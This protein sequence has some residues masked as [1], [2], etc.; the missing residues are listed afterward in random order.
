M[1]RAFFLKQFQLVAGGRI[2]LTPG[3][4]SL[5]LDSIGPDTQV[6]LRALPPPPVTTTA[7]ATSSLLVGS[8]INSATSGSNS[9][10]SSTGS[11]S[12]T[13]SSNIIIFRV[14]A[15]STSTTSSSTTTLEALQSGT[16]TNPYGISTSYNS[17]GNGSQTLTAVSGTFTSAGNIIEPLPT[18]QPIQTVPPAPPGVILKVNHIRGDLS[19]PIN[20]Q[21]DAEIFG[22]DHTTQQIV[23]FDLNLNTKTAVVDPKF[24]PI[25]VPGN[26]IAAG[27]DLAW[28]GHMRVLLFS[29]G[30]TVYAYNPLT[31][32]ELGS[33]TD[34]GSFL[35]SLPINAVAGTDTLVVLGS[36][37]TNELYAINLTKSLQTGVAQPAAGSPASFIPQPQFYLLGG[38]TSSPGN[39]L[40]F[41]TIAAHLDTT[42]PDMFQLG[43]QAVGTATVTKV[44]G[45]G[46]VLS[47]NTFTA[48]A[49][50]AVK[51]GTAYINVSNTLP[52]TTLP[53]PALGSIDQSLAGVESSNGTTNT[54]D[55]ETGTYTFDYPDPLMGLSESFRPDLVGSALIDVQGTVQNIRGGTATGMVLNDT[56]NLNLVKFNSISNS[57]I[58]GQPVGHLQ[59][60]HRSHVLVLTPSRDVY[61]RNGVTVNKNLTVIGPL[62]QPN[63]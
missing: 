31:G 25:S 30:T 26:P 7:L 15:T 4:N 48:V 45:M 37:H 13:S 5:I 23:R 56:G 8:N 6:S 55:T 14:F 38:L 52:A 53:G 59:F 41:G 29:S 10:T 9:T 50:V 28:D 42:Q 47:N 20:V 43:V 54:V 12:S 19:A 22:Y 24:T 3:V 18:T 34:V 2:D 36:Y 63:D 39:N 62:T 27:V 44:P 21:T 35:G 51:Q 17:N 11:S 61:G 57:T 46:S 60:K 32:Q 40:V 49:N 33:F 58:V 1:I 16:I